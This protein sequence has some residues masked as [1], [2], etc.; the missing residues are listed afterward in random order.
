MDITVDELRRQFNDALGL[1]AQ[2][3]ERAEKATKSERTLSDAYL[4]LREILRAWK[5]PHA[6]TPEQVWAH[7]EQCARDAVATVDRRAELLRRALEALMC[8]QEVTFGH[9]C[10][11]CDSEVLQ[12]DLLLPAD[13]ARELAGQ[14]EE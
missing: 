8:G 14:K 1:I 4:R 13:I 6:P 2:L 11:R 12:Y 3:R 10:G 9:R 7:T 5:T